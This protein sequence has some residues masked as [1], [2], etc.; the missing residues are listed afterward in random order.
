MNRAPVA[1]RIEQGTP[2]PKVASSILAGRTIRSGPG[3]GR[4]PAILRTPLP[5]ASI[6]GRTDLGSVLF[7]FENEFGGQLWPKKKR[8]SW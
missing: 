2:K 3:G 6:G 7:M 5:C 1:Q 8:A 4:P